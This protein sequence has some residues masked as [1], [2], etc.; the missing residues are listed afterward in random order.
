MT[1]R[2]ADE[3]AWRAVENLVGSSSKIAAETARLFGISDDDEAFAEVVLGAIRVRATIT[4]RVQRA[5]KAA[6]AVRIRARREA[7][8][9]PRYAL[10]ALA[11]VPESW[12]VDI[13]RGRGKLDSARLK[14][15]EA[16]LEGRE[17]GK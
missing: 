3:M 7:T 6:K 9:L 14:A 15:V 16:A 5:N 13:E 4:A 8:G 12:I 11:G 2:E 1:P 17:R 10:A